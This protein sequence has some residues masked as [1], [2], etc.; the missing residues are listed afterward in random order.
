MNDAT[1]LPNGHEYLILEARHSVFFFRK[2]GLAV[3]PFSIL[4][5][6]IIVM[7][8]ERIHLLLHAPLFYLF[9]FLMKSEW[10]IYPE[11]KL[12]FYKL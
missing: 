9:C 6:I 8:R 7:H 12:L 5:N 2:P 4:E 1:H 3:E 11:K 10:Q